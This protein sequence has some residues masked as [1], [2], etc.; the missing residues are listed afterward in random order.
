MIPIAIFFALCSAVI[1]YALGYDSGH[2]AGHR[3]TMNQL[4]QSR[5]E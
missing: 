5:G 4:E 2:A 1:L 3:E